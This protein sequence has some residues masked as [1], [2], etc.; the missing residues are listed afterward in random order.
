MINN[1]RILANPKFASIKLTSQLILN[2]LNNE[3]ESEKFVPMK[4]QQYTLRLCIEKSLVIYGI[5]YK[6]SAAE[7]VYKLRNINPKSKKQGKEK[8]THTTEIESDLQTTIS[9]MSELLFVPDRAIRSTGLGLSII[10]S[11]I[12]PSSQTR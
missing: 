6:E 2:S 11:S 7:R 3:R 5:G 4:N 12:V 1:L 10:G 8:K 9:T